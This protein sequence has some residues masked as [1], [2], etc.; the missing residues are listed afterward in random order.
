M[1]LVIPY[2]LEREEKRAVVRDDLVVNI[3]ESNSLPAFRPQEFYP[4]KIRAHRDLIFKILKGK[5]RLSILVDD[6]TRPTPAS[7]ALGELLDIAE[8]S[9]IGDTRIIVAFGSHEFPPEEYLIKKVGKAVYSRLPII[10]HDAYTR[11]EHRSI[12]YTSRGTPL[13]LNRWVVSSDVK[14][15]IGSIFPSSL[16]GFTGGGKMILP[17]V[18]YH[19]SIDYNHAMFLDSFSGVIDGN[20]MRD[21]MEEAARLAGLDLIIDSVLTPDG[22]VVSL[23]IGDLISAH[24]EGVEISRKVY[25]KPVPRAGIVVIG[26]GST[27]DIDFVHVSKALEVANS[28]CEEG[29]IIVLVGACPLG[30]RWDELID[31]LKEEAVNSENPQ[32]E[33]FA[34]LFLKRYSSIFLTRSKLVFWVTQAEH[35]DTAKKLGFEFFEDLQSAVNEAISRKKTASITV[36]P[37][38]SLLLPTPY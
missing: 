37:R 32:G 24:R 36:L 2:N 12:G 6:H 33:V 11:K 3:V 8:V 10:L 16:A 9:R 28:V 21:D 18:A 14:I 35:E 23:H 1:D 19:A 17:G 29:G 5:S 7:H 22:K 25:E 34:H 31:A 38:G 26:C 20:P 4:E 27:D 15:S 13:L 30:I